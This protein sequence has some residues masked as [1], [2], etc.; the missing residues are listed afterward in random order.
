MV[1]IESFEAIFGWEHITRYSDLS[2]K[3]FPIVWS[4]VA[5]PDKVARF[6]SDNWSIFYRA[7][8]QRKYSEKT[9]WKVGRMRI[10]HAGVR[11]VSTC[12]KVKRDQ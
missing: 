5:I 2:R 9:D 11:R 3:H 12:R 10:E 8:D 7:F 6:G 4:Q 1:E